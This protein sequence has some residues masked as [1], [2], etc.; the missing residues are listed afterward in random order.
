[1][2]S[3]FEVVGHGAGLTC[4]TCPYTACSHHHVTIQLVSITM[5]I[6]GSSVYEVL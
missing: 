1:M 2:Q 6:V 3:L 4:K 5:V